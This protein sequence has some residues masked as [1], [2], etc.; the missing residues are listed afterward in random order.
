MNSGSGD[1]LSS[2]TLP[3]L[4]EICDKPEYG[5][6]TK[7]KPEKGCIKLLRTTDIS[8]GPID[9]STVPFCEQEPPTPEKFLLSEGDIVISRAGSVGLSAL[10]R[11]CPR[12]I[13]ASYLIRFRSKPQLEKK[14]LHYF[15]CGPSYWEQISQESAGIALQNVNAKKLSGITIPLAPLPEQRRIAAAIETQ[16]TRLDAS[17]AALK[18]A[19]ANLKRYR[20]STLKAACEGRLVPVE[21]ELARSEGREYEPA[22]VLLERILAERRVRWKSQE[23]RRG[24][25]REPSA[26]DTSAL[27]ELRDGW[28]WASLESIS[29][30]RLGRQRSPKRASGPH[31]RPYLRAAVQRKLLLPACCVKRRCYRNSEGVFGAHRAKVRGLTRVETGRSWLAYTSFL[32]ITPRHFLTPRWRVRKWVS[33]NRSGRWEH[34]RSS[35]VLAVMSGSVSNHP[36]MSCHAP[37]KGSGRVRQWRGLRF[38]GA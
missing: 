6:T 7:A 24:K 15:L 8:K 38:R 17:V 13:F 1:I 3:S 34:S 27:P 30:V 25:Y 31:M 36:R 26:P 20:A 32:A 23:K 2:W 5:W 9:W 29:E 35:I 12:A 11:N 33:L 10:I 22:D 18:R 28:V 37:S 14:Y 16:F 4:G 19:Q 21:A